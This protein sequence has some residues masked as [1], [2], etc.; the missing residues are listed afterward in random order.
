MKKLYIL[1]LLLFSFTKVYALDCYTASQVVSFGGYFHDDTGTLVNPTSPKAVLRI[2]PFTGTSTWCDNTGGTDAC[3]GTDEGTLPA[4]TNLTRGLLGAKT[5]FYGGEYTIGS[6][7]AEGT[8]EISLE[9]TVPTAKDVGKVVKVFQ[10]RTQ[11]PTSI[12]VSTDNI[13]INWADVS[14]PTSTVGLSNTTI[15]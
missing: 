7:A 15:N 3:T 14:N 9:G 6:A 8:R 11:C 12:L 10:V 1:L 13:G 2:T 5:G 4:P